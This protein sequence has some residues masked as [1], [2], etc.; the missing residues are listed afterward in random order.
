MDK[1]L[2]KLQIFE[3]LILNM[4]SLFCSGLSPTFVDCV[5]HLDLRLRE[6]GSDVVDLDRGD[7]LVV[8]GRGRRRGLSELSDLKTKEVV[9]GN[10]G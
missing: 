5:D 1:Q 3:V 2:T 6:A 7:C 8:V 10:I 9:R 4:K